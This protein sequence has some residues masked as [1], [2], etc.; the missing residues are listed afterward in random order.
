MKRSLLIGA[1]VALPIL[2]FAGPK[3][4]ARKHIQKA[5]DAHA[6]GKYDVA[7]SELEAAYALDP[8]PDLL[9]AI[10]QVHVKLGHC[11]DA[12]AS[13]EKF[14][15]TNPPAEP[16]AAAK[17]AIETCKAQQPEPAPEPKPEPKPE[18]PPPPPPEAEP[19]Y[20][21]FIGDG[22]VGVGVASGVVG[23]IMYAGALGALDQAD[24]AQ[25]Y[26]DHQK[27]VSDATTKRNLAIVFGGV[28]VVAIGVGVWHFTSFHA[29]QSKVAFVPTASGGMLAWMGRF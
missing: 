6:Q 17:E 1:L 2:A 5:T 15:A 27:F 7:L 23:G 9:Y 18:P 11:P 26:T 19:F 21:D 22:L 28:A 3:D 4:E 13:Y 20:M 25:T 12:I 16:S 14:L 29:E 10:G 24:A 8:Q